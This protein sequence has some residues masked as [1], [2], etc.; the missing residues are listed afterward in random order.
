MLWRPVPGFVPSEQAYAPAVAYQQEGWAEVVRLRDRGVLPPDVDVDRA[1][2]T[3]TAV[4]SGVISQQLSNA[5]HEPF[6]SG[7][8][9]STL[10]D[11]VD[12]WLAHHG[13][14]SPRP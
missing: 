14:A 3:W 13:T 4:I 1:F 9:P 2:R 12:M 11:V 6:E 7:I 8:F 5:P 10:P